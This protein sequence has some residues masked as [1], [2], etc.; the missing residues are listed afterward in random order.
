M[1]D[2]KGE[3]ELSVKR[4]WRSRGRIA[5]RKVDVKS[6]YDHVAA[7]VPGEERGHTHEHSHEHEHSHQ[8]EHEH[9]HRHEHEHA[10]SILFYL[11]IEDS[12]HLL[13]FVNS[14]S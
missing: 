4:V 5:A 2:L 13:T 11:I 9:E 12:F 14:V 10:V 1:P 7:P 8:H 6:I 3:F